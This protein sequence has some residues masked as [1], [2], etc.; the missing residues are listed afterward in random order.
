MA[1]QAGPD[2]LAVD[3]ARLP[4]E[5]QIAFFRQKLNLPTRHYD[6]LIKAQHDRGFMVAG[7]IKADLL[8]DLRKTVDKAISEGRSIQWFREQFDGIVEKHGWAY[9]GERDWRTRVIYKTNMAASYAAGRWQ[10]LNDPDLLA[11]RP[12]WKYIHNDT[13]T[14]PRPLHV[15]WSGL[16]LR[17]DDPWWQ[18]HFPP[19][20]WGCR[21]RVTAVAKP[22]PD[23]D[24]A[25]DDGTYI[26]V[27]RGGEA[28][29]IPKGIDYGWDYVPGQSNAELLRQVIDKQ[30]GAAWQLAKANTEALVK[31]PVF[32]SF[33]DGVIQGE[34]P[35]A[36]LDP[37]EQALLESAAL[38]VLL[39]DASIAA[40][41]EK[42]PEI[43]LDDYRRVQEIIDR[44]DIYRQG[45]ERLIYLL[46]NGVWYRAALKR[47]A[48]K[49][50]NYFLMLFKDERGKPPGGA[51]KV[52]R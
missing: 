8:D 49:R 22:D 5:E 48:D 10:Q 14:H 47:T 29:T 30:D 39:S 23:R 6:D 24:T 45:E 32:K 17:H 43:G 9:K 15:A 1:L 37:R 13:V 20:G 36:V 25:P 11:S 26:K 46:L 27:D 51:V 2:T 21:C 52:E 28:H 16:T 44:G 3:N 18:T 41:E 7:A 12:W 38:T 33:F 42:H 19:N 35:I 40:H 4:F 34:F 50:K 31:S